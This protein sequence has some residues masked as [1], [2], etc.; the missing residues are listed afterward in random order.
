MYSEESWGKGKPDAGA[1]TG[2]IAL[3]DLFAS[4]ADCSRLGFV[5]TFFVF[6][7]NIFASLFLLLMPAAGNDISL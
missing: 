3:V 1:C 7:Q 5:D 6:S 2:D 4:M